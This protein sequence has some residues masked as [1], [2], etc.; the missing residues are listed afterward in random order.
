MGCF[1]CV[2][3]CATKHGAQVQR[4]YLSDMSAG[5]QPFGVATKDVRVELLGND[6]AG[7]VAVGASLLIFG[8]VGLTW[9]SDT[10]A[11]QAWSDIQVRG[12]LQTQKAAS[13]QIDT[14]SG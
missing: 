1:S 9:A 8:T 7:Q 11:V 4:I 13:G 2:H 14:V 10:S 6:L 12:S 3:A 5:S